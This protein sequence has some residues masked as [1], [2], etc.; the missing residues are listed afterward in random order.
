MLDGCAKGHARKQ[1]KHHWRIMYGDRTY[2]DF[3]LGEHGARKDP[4][5]Q[6]GHIKKM[7][8]HLGILE[9]AKKRIQALM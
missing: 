2:H 4:D 9:C 3:P 5:I 7:A 8:R 1:T 6:I